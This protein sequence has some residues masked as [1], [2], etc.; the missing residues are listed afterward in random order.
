MAHIE[1][2]LRERRAIE[3]MLN[4]KVPVSRIAAEIGRHRSTVYREIRQSLI[5][6]GEM[7]DLLAQPREI[8][9]KPGAGSLKIDGGKV[10]GL[11][12]HGGQVGGARG[13][14]HAIGSLDA[15]CSSRCARSA[16]SARFSSGVSSLGFSFFT[17]AMACCR[18]PCAAW[19]IL[20]SAKSFV[21]PII[22]ATTV[23]YSVLP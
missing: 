20:V 1:L 22:K 16:S 18:M 10:E 3:D 9:D 8:S 7:F 2:D 17:A 13:L 21:R 23:F 19:T 6:M 5:D 14:A 15:P 11:A 4:A 12:H